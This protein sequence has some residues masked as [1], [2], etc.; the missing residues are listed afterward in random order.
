MSQRPLEW[1]QSD[2]IHDLDLDGVIAYLE[3]TVVEKCPAPEAAE[4]LLSQMREAA[5]KVS[6]GLYEP[7]NRKHYQELASELPDEMTFS[8][9]L[10]NLLPTVWSDYRLWKVFAMKPPESA[11]LKNAL[12]SYCLLKFYNLQIPFRDSVW[13]ELRG[14]PKKWNYLQGLMCCQARRFFRLEDTSAKDE[15]NDSEKMLLNELSLGQLLYQYARQPFNDWRPT[16]RQMDLPA[17]VLR[18]LSQ[19]AGSLAKD[20]AWLAFNPGGY[21]AG[22]AP[23]LDH[24]SRNLGNAKTVEDMVV[25]LRQAP[26]LTDYALAK[27]SMGSLDPA[28]RKLAKEAKLLAL[29]RERLPV[30]FHKS[31]GDKNMP[32]SAV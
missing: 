23:A 31:R 7:G 21:R 8:E 18:R 12:A 2:L 30:T 5:P 22:R 14:Q 11:V 6:L 3:R 13:L 25:R 24:R 27:M 19:A 16:L 20:A 29:Y 28:G 4:K 10:G 17:T 26:G 32:T 1:P 15:L 9:R